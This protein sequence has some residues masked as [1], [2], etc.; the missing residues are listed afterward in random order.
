MNKKKS[1]K[2]VPKGPS[3]FENFYKN[4]LTGTAVYVLNIVPPFNE[5]LTA[6]FLLLC[7]III[8]NFGISYMSALL[9]IL[10]APSMIIG[11]Y[12]WAG[13]RAFMTLSFIFAG[14]LVIKGLIALVKALGTGIGEKMEEAEPTPPPGSILKDA[15]TEIGKKAAELIGEGGVVTAGGPKGAVKRSGKSFDELIRKFKELMQH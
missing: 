5:N 11:T 7:C 2:P 3:Q 6:G 12:G 14:W 1:K 8:F 9:I 15:S 10:F 4:F 13:S